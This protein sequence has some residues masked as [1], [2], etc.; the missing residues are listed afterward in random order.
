MTQLVAK[1]KKTP[2]IYMSE[3]YIFNPNEGRLGETLQRAALVTENQLLIALHEQ[4]RYTDLK[5]GEILALR[6]WIAEKTVEFFAERW[7]S[8]LAQERRHPLGYYLKEAGLLSDEQIERVLAVQEQLLL[9]F[10]EIVVQQGWL[11][12]STL[13]FFLQHL[14][15]GGSSGSA[16]G[17]RQASPARENREFAML[18]DLS[19]D[20]STEVFTIQSTDTFLAEDRETLL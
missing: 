4:G 12:Q 13:D 8:L 9:R 6:G 16:D 7:P 15:T 5:I 2:T 1:T 11:K 18:S 20:D 19:V 3:P 10:G 14:C 17:D